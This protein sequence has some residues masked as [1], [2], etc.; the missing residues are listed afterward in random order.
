[1]KTQALFTSKDKSETIKMS[2]A[3]IF[4]WR[5]QG[6]LSFFPDIKSSCLDALFHKTLFHLMLL[7][8]NGC[9]CYSMDVAVI[10]WITSCHENRMTIG[11]ITPW[12]EYETSLRMSVSA[13]HFLIEIMFIL[14]AIKF[15]IKRSYDKQNFTLV[16]ILY[17]IYETSLFFV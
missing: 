10:Q 2:S 5:L 1:M 3:A 11:V 16:F 7:L 17:E 14:K 8:F 12:H 6:Q 13:M 9:C 4:V 15:H